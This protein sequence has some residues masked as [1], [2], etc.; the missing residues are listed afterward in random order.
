MFACA[1]VCL[2]ARVILYLPF[3]CNGGVVF[4]WLLPLFLL[5]GVFSFSLLHKL[6]FHSFTVSSGNHSFLPPSLPPSILPFA[7]LARA[8]LPLSPYTSHSFLLL[9]HTRAYAIVFG[10]VSLSQRTCL[11]PF[12]SGGMH[13]ILVI[14]INVLWMGEKKGRK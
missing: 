7:R 8:I 4:W 5:L 11:P 14:G 9:S 3:Y 10:S 6:C 12:L 1:R 2:C 13:L